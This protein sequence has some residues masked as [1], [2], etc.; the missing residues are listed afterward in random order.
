MTL[1][2]GGMNYI[3]AANN[4]RCLRLSVERV[5]VDSRESRLQFHQDL[6]R[7][8]GGSSSLMIDPPEKLEN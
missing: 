8:R 2:D 5:R 6:L 4:L 7:G 1:A 3:R